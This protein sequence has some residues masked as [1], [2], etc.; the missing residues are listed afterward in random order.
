MIE[1]FRTAEFNKW[2]VGLSDTIGVSRIQARID[3][4]GIGLFGD[5]RP[6]GNGVSELRVDT[7]PG[8]RIYFFQRGN[9][10]IIL[11]CGGDKS[12]QA[13]DIQK[14][15]ALAKEISNDN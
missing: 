4:L 5:V 8:Y 1:I 14:A 7:G 2:L 11:L 12:S 13:K 6:V 15:K 9:K 10:L 3:R